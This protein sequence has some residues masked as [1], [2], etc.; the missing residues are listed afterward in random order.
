MLYSYT[1]IRNEVNQ[2]R[3]PFTLSIEEDVIK[4][5][6][7]KAIDEN[8]NVSELIELWVKKL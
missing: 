3:K 1:Y 2:M 6:K 8:T 5:L 4:T 7:K